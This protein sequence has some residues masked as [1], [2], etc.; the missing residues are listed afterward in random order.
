MKIFPGSLVALVLFC[1]S[2][3]LVLPGLAQAAQPVDIEKTLAVEL[4]EIERKSREVEPGTGPLL[5]RVLKDAYSSLGPKPVPPETA[6]EFLL[7]A[8]RV[9]ISLARNNFLQPGRKEDWPNS[10]GEAL[11]PITSSHQG[12]SSS[13]A[14][15]VMVRTEYLNRLE[16]IRFLDCD[17][18][19]LLLISVAQMVGFELRLVE[20][21]GHNFVRWHGPGGQ[22]VNWDWTRWASLDDQGY[23]ERIP[24]IQ[25]TRKTYLKSQTQ[26]EATG[27]FLAV[28]TRNISDPAKK[29][30]LRRDALAKAPNNPIV[31]NNVAWSFATLP[32]GVE[33]T[34]RQDAVSLAL[35]A[36]ASDPDD[37]EFMDTAACAL[38]AAGQ[39]AIAIAIEA[40]AEAAASGSDRAAYR[41]NREL[42]EQGQRC[43]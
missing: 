17:M 28:L 37:P 32:E 6:E 40:G 8:E 1:L 19:S 14:S 5:R 4:F 15:D 24:P 20:V 3:A 29:L 10:I 25:L 30:A 41:K 38:A 22:R 23:H 11:E 35:S 39:K 18:A 16:P 42:I 34:E 12:W 21:P 33:H 9:T 7:L 13:L 36:W 2:E 26:E 31:A 43:Q 27:Y